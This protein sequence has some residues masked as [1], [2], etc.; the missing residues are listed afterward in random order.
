MMWRALGLYLNTESPIVVVL[1]ESMEP[2]VQRGDL[3]LL[4]MADNRIDIG[5]ICV[6]KLRGRDIP[7][8]H[9]VIKSHD[10]TRTGGK[11]F[12]LTKGD[13]NSADDRGLYNRGQNWIHR[14]DVMG[15][16]LG[17][18]PQMGMLTILMN[19]YPWARNVL[20]GAMG[21]FTLTTREN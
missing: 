14:S 20:L 6:F 7:I 4:S 15:R 16:V 17:H 21:L 10:E 8:V 5:D 9:R 13:N 1:S 2:M 3:L 11:Q 19:D 12:I 18:F